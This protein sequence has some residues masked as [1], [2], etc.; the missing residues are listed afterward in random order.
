MNIADSTGFTL[1][2]FAVSSGFSKATDILIKAG[3]NVNAVDNS[4]KSALNYAAQNSR[5]VCMSLLINA[6]ADI[7][8]AT[9]KRFTNVKLM[10][11][12]MIAAMYGHDNCIKLLLR[13]GADVNI[14][15]IN[16]VN[17]LICAAT[18]GHNISIQLLVKAGADVNSCDTSRTTALAYAVRSQSLLS[19]EA[20]IKAGADVNRVH[21]HNVTPLLAAA[22]GHESL[23]PLGQCNLRHFQIIRYLLA[24]GAKV[25]IASKDRKTALTTIIYRNCSQCVKAL[26]RA[27]ADVNIMPVIGQTPFF[28]ALQMTH[29]DI[30]LLLMSAGAIVNMVYKDGNTTHF[31]APVKNA[32][33]TTVIATISL[34]IN[35]R[36][37]YKRHL[38]C[39]PH[40]SYNITGT[41]L[42]AR[43][44][45]PLAALSQVQDAP[46]W[47]LY[48]RS[49]CREVI[50]RQMTR[51]NPHENLF[52][53]IPRLGLPEVLEKYLLYDVS[54]DR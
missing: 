53:R 19:V 14:A 25:N 46:N 6:G 31:K 15:N 17:S 38:A 54:F 16:A 9:V 13:G 1:L 4:H 24:K 20:L 50:R 28:V 10:T 8:H 7:N 3:A 41:P 29:N 45:D 12:L 32:D 36:D 30:P 27:G 48:L 43:K 11:S 44:E 37:P 51:V 26:I 23:E 18:N 52:V 2:M 33:S 22:E 5:D 49:Q 34:R 40:I 35:S 21:K 39:A 47:K 42:A